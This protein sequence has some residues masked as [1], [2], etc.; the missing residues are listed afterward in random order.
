M[1]LL[2]TLD[3]RFTRTRD[4]QV[5]SQTTYSLPF[6]DRYL[7]VFDGVKIV[8][9]A[10]HKSDVDHRYR[11]VVGPGVEFLEVPYYLGPWQYAKVR[12]RVRAAVRSAL[13][14]NDAVLCRVGSRVATDLLPLLWKQRRP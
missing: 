7:K 5:W 3:F 4:G 14:P 12:G 11:P 2:I 8:A 10:E 9:R 13:S 6:W 1:K